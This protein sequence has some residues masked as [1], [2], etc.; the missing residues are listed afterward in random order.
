[1]TDW[2]SE[3]DLLRVA[4]PSTR[5]TQQTGKTAQQG[6]QQGTQQRGLKALALQAL[7]RNGVRNND[8]T[9]SEKPRN[10]APDSEPQFVARV[11]LPM[12]RNSATSW[13]RLFYADGSA[14]TIYCPTPESSTAVIAATG[15]IRAEPIQPNRPATESELSELRRLVTRLCVDAG[16]EL[17][18]RTVQAALQDVDQALAYFRQ[19]E[20]RHGVTP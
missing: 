9:K 18:E 20:Q 15:A 12:A 1:M 2:T 3:S 19:Y 8:A 13:W 7:A 17:I 14:S 10:N 6:A 11:A 16:S 5:N 4:P